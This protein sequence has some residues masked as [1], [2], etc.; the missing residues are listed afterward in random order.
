MR[1]V[2]GGRIAMIF[3][4]PMTALNPVMT[5]GGQIDEMLEVHTKLSTPRRA[6]QRASRCWRSCV[7]P[8]RSACSRLP[9]PAV[10]RAAPAG[11]IA[12]ALI[13][14]AGAA[15]RRRADH[16]A[17]RHDAG[18]DP[19]ADPRA[20]ARA[21]IGVL[22]ITHDFGVVA[23]IADRVAV[24][25]HGSWSS[26]AGRAR[27]L[28]AAA[29]SVHAGADR[30]R[31]ESQPATR[32]RR[33]RRAAVV[34]TS[35][36]LDKTYAF[37]RRLFGR[38]R[39]VRAARDVE[40]Q[41]RR[42]ETLGLVGESGSGKSTRGALHRAADRCRSAA[43]PHRRRRPDRSLPRATAARRIAS[44][45]RWCF[46]IRIASLNPRRTVGSIDHRGADRAW[47]AAIRGDGARAATA[48]AR[49]SRSRGAAERF[50]HEFS[51]GQRQRIG[52]ARAL[53]LEPEILVADEPV[54]ALDVSVQAQVLRLLDDM[55]E[56]LDLAMLFIT[57]DL[58]VA[59]QVCDRSP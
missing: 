57:H 45:S 35:I 6:E 17:R 3:Q 55:R 1:E 2:R 53:A 20:A 13:A 26:R 52:I 43:R 33:R 37:R 24:M 59:A 32:A 4:E 44:A 23:E 48:R 58:R 42:G 21:H 25:Q 10:R 56:R 30:R 51:G 28:N 16:R 50:P 18:A 22:F 47:R 41:I 14:R 11:M 39:R 31:A 12:M 40:L 36:G 9:A 15:D 49:R 8:S 46:R 38:E 5:I 34:L 7:C 19:R 27:C 54:S 29:A